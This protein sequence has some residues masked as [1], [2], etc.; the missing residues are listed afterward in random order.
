M[1]REAISS[2]TGKTSGRRPTLSHDQIRE[3]S[4]T[5]FVREAVDGIEAW[6]NDL[7]VRGLEVQHFRGTHHSIYVAGRW[8]GGYY[9]ARFWVH[10]WLLER[11]P[12]DEELK[13]LSDVS[14]LRLEQN[15]VSGNLQSDSDLDLYRVAV[16]ARLE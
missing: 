9:F 15:R 10:F 7:G 3:R 14:S 11:R 5:E 16:K 2:T 1:G 12:S 6:L 13:G 4:S 8:L